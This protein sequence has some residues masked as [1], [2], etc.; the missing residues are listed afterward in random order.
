MSKKLSTLFLIL[1]SL[2]T[3]S[4]CEHEEDYNYIEY[5][6]LNNKAIELYDYM[7]QDYNDLI[8]DLEYSGLIIKSKT[9]SNA[10]LANST[11]SIVY[12]IECNRNSRIDYARVEYFTN[13]TSLALDRYGYWHNDCFDLGFDINY[14]GEIFTYDQDLITYYNEA[15][16]INDYSAMKYNIHDCF[17]DWIGVSYAT[18]VDYLALSTYE[19]R[20]GIQVCDKDVLKNTKKSR[21]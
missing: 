19:R 12:Y 2:F 20:I 16:F 7:G 4:S 18:G 13:K 15:E 14:Y 10:R 8:D 5:N 17:E 9:S 1:I 21:K 11:G 3:F 6:N